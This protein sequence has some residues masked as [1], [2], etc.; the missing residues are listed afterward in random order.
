M[1]YFEQEPSLGPH[2]L[3]LEQDSCLRL[4]RTETCR[5]MVGILCV[6]KFAAPRQPDDVADVS[7]IVSPYRSL[8]FTPPPP[9][10]HSR[11]YPAMPIAEL[12]SLTSYHRATTAPYRGGGGAG[13]G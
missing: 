13:G 7:V 4:T 3:D 8:F 6:R 12:L 2:A 1:G 10:T 5:A 11:S 9:L